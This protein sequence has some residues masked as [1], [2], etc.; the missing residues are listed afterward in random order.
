MKSKVLPFV[1]FVVFMFIGVVYVKNYYMQMKYYRIACREQK[2][3]SMKSVF[4]FASVVKAYTPGSL[5][6]KRAIKE[7]LHMYKE[8]YRNKRYRNAFYILEMMKA[9]LMSIRSFYQPY[10]NVL[11]HVTMSIEGLSKDIKHNDELNR[12]MPP[13][14]GYKP[15][16]PEPLFYI[17]LLVF[18]GLWVY[19]SIAFLNSLNEYSL[20]NGRFLFYMMALF[21]SW[22]G[23]VAF[24]FMA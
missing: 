19:F 2:I 4:Y 16:Q 17:A 11:L 15:Y 24:L 18:F 20:E 22:A 5:Y 13:M 14:K 9:S 7:L 21:A 23:W 10:R 8:E 3:D 1:V 12:V 6:V